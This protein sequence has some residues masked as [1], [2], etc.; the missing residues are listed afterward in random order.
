MVVLCHS[1]KDAAART[2]G[3]DDD[4][5][6][7]SALPALSDLAFEF[8]VAGFGSG[9]HKAAD[10][11][12]EPFEMHLHAARSRRRSSPSPLQRILSVPLESF[13]TKL[14]EESSTSSEGLWHGGE[15]DYADAVGGVSGGKLVLLDDA[16]IHLYAMSHA[17]PLDGAPLLQT[18]PPPNAGSFARTPA[19]RRYVEV[20]TILATE[21]AQDDFKQHFD[22]VEQI[23]FEDCGFSWVSA[24]PA[25]PA[26]ADS[27]G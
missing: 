2:H 8:D 25:K 5:L 17:L 10:D 22:S 13:C 15:E 14:Q 24:Q 20:G 4:A 11:A 19:T 27:Q 23:A 1:G 9:S 12:P 3:F 26:K 18:T 7:D 21:R 16:G 6:M